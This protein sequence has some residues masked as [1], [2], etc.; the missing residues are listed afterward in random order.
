MES[1]L[2]NIYGITGSTDSHELLT[3]VQSTQEVSTQNR[4]SYSSFWG[5]LHKG[6]LLLEIMI[7]NKKIKFNTVC[8]NML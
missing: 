1:Q 7:Y 8:L 6:I 2:R 4:A 3:M 5:S